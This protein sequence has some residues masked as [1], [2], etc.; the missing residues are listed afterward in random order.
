MTENATVL[1]VDDDPVVR[2]I[3]ATLLEEDGYQVDTAR[4]GEEG[5]R[6]ATEHQPDAIILDVNMP[7]MDGW[8][9]LDA[10]RDR[11]AE[12]RAPVLVLSTVR[13]WAEAMRRGAKAYLSKPFDLETLEITLSSV[14]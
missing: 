13:D 9:F 6:R 8:Q 7:V 1:V 14:L 11:P 10:W 5:L 4:D 12:R 2:D 3:I